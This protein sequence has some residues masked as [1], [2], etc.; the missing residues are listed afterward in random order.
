M[1]RLCLF[2]VFCDWKECAERLLNEFWF[3]DGAAVVLEEDELCQCADR[4]VPHLLLGIPLVF[5]QFR[6]ASDVVLASQREDLQHFLKL[7]ELPM[8]SPLRD[9]AHSPDAGL[10]EIIIDLFLIFA[11]V[12][13]QLH[14]FGSRLPYNLIEK[15]VVSVFYAIAEEAH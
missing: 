8:R 6:I 2:Q 10:K 9:A 14:E 1:N 4:V 3:E 13:D 12:M 15:Y 11:C 7:R 5:V